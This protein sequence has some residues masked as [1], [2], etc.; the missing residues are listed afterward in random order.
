MH[1]RETL[2]FWFCATNATLCRLGG[3]SFGFY[4]FMGL[5]TF[6]LVSETASRWSEYKA[7]KAAEAN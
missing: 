6:Y 7:D 5:G 3:D 1:L 2:A 4:L